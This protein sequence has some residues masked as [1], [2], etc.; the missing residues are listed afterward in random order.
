MRNQLAIDPAEAQVIDASSGAWVMTRPCHAGAMG[1]LACFCSIGGSQ[2]PSCTAAGIGYRPRGLNLP[3]IHTHGPGGRCASPS[4]VMTLGKHPTARRVQ[5]W[6]IR[7]RSIRR[8]QRLR[9]FLAFRRMCRPL[10]P[11]ACDEELGELSGAVPG[12]VRGHPPLR[13]AMVHSR[14]G[15]PTH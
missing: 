15:S 13:G 3:S 5:T 12:G 7:Y 9:S 8:T 2:D 10:S 4:R 6:R 14:F 1:D 11:P